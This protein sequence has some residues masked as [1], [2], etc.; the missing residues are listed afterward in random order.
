MKILKTI[1]ISLICVGFLIIGTTHIG[2]V[3]SRSF[4]EDISNIFSDLAASTLQT[5]VHIKSK[6]SG[7][8]TNRGSMSGGAGII[9]DKSGYI[10]TNSHVIKNAEEIQITTFNDN[11][12]QA[13]VVGKDPKLDIALLKI[14][15]NE[16]LSV[17]KIGDSDKIKIGELVMVI[18]S[19]FGFVNSVSVGVIS[20]KERL[21]N[22]GP[23]D[24]FIQ[25]DAAMNPGNSGG[26]LLN[27]NGEVIGVNTLIISE[28]DRSIDLGFAIPINMVMAVVDQLKK[29]GKVIRGWLGVI[30][31]PITSE[32]KKARN[33]PSKKGA[34]VQNISEGSPAAKSDLKEGD[35][36]IR[37]DG[38]EI[39]NM[40]I[41]PFIIS[42]SPLG[43]ELEAVVLRK[44]KEKIIKIILE[45]QD[46]NR[47]FS[48]PELHSK[49]GFF[50]KEITPELAK[51]LSKKNNRI[52]EK[53]VVISKVK[54][55][56][57]ACKKLMENDLILSVNNK[58]VEAIED[59]ASIMLQIS[60]QDLLLIT[61]L[62]EGVKEHVVLK[63]D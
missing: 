43:E 55:G 17:A 58:K 29:N 40:H 28:K 3:E 63:L 11:D 19:P 26:P 36:I 8:K 52:I 20:G 22:V 27:I 18:G 25:T 5:T 50:V 24:N 54:A 46:P 32:L 42:M 60:T 6:T 39:K 57:L 33:L 49:Y 62:R 48:I 12:Y 2:N 53:G 10:I 51:E 23:F 34:Y 15:P 37:F 1:F 13:E 47:A 61:V 45:E 14:E 35:I 41:L 31:R 59:Y 4:K 21:L 44:G 38:K 30:I 56:S 7:P 16:Q 9:I